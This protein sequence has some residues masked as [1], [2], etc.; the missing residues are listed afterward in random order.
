MAFTTDENSRAPH[1]KLSVE[2]DREVR[3][4]M[5]GAVYAWCRNNDGKPFAARDLFG[6]RNWEGTPL[7]KIWQWH[8]DNPGKRDTDDAAALDVGYYLKQ[9]IKAEKRVFD[10]KDGTAPHDPRTYWLIKT[11]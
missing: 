4:F 2:D 7:M 6:G 3:A 5:Q 1:A 10:T 8:R 11:E 9:V